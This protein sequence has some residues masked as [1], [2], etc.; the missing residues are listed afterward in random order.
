MP[1]GGR[2]LKKQ[3]KFPADDV[4][5]I[6]SA[7]LD[8]NVKLV[9]QGFRVFDKELLLSGLLQQLINFEKYEIGTQ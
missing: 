1:A 5:I 7:E 4:I 9:K 8:A 3:P 6:S 2:M